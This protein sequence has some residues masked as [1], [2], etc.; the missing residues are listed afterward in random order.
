MND[1]QYE[2]GSPDWLAMLEEIFGQ[3]VAAGGQS[4][5]VDFSMCEVYTDVPRISAEPQV[6][7]H[8]RVKEDEMMFLARKPTMWTSRSSASGRSSSR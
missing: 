2:L 6:G 5:D 1:D 7:W 3:T 8:L 4:V